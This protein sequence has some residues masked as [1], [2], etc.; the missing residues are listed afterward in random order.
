MAIDKL[1]FWN[2]LNTPGRH[3]V[4]I[5]GTT[6]VVHSFGRGK[7][8]AIC[9]VLPSDDAEV[10]RLQLAAANKALDNAI[11]KVKNESA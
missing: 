6:H 9:S 1:P 11:Q 10:A 8:A 3:V 4:V 7:K 2:A 5:D